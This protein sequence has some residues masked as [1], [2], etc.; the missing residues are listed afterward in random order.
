MQLRGAFAWYVLPLPTAI[1]LL[2]CRGRQARTG[3]GGQPICSCLL[4]ARKQAEASNG[5]RT[6]A[7]RAAREDRL[8]GPRMPRGFF[9]RRAR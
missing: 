9:W 7:R 4:G 5:R 2:G 1:S 6:R 3:F 8:V